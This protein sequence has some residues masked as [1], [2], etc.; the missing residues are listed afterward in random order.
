ML[1]FTKPG[2]TQNNAEDVSSQ[3]WILTNIYDE[4]YLNILVKILKKF[5]NKINLLL[6]K[7]TNELLKLG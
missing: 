6:S 7:T 1:A 3:N 5:V 2:D 4:I